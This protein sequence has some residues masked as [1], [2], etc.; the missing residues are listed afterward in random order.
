MN[1]ALRINSLAKANGFANGENVVL[2]AEIPCERTFVTEFASDC[3]GL[4]RSVFIIFGTFPNVSRGF[5]Y[6]FMDVPPD[7]CLFPLSQPIKSTYTTF[8]KGSAT[9]SGPFQE[10]HRFGKPPVSQFVT[11]LIHCK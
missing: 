11:M 3:D 5:L 4:A 1:Q 6:F 2:A 10:T 9:Q 7:F 8:L